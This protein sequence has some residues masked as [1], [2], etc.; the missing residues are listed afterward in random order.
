M[1]TSFDL[2]GVNAGG[3]AA[4]GIATFNGTEYAINSFDAINTFIGAMGVSDAGIS[5]GGK[6][7]SL[8]GTLK[9]EVRTGVKGNWDG[10][11]VYNANAS[12][13]NDKNREYFGVFYRQQ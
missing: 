10:S 9:A 12:W 2:T 11:Y 1:A 4:D 8:L 5:N 13:I 3:K 7:Q 6:P